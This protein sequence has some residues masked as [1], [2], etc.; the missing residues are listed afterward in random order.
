MG[1][2]KLTPQNG[3]TYI[4][5][6]KDNAGNSYETKLPAAKESG[7]TIAITLQPNARSFLVQRSENAAANFHK[8][9]II[10]TMQQRL[11]YAA[12]IDLSQTPV[13]GGAI[14]VGDLPSGILQ[15]TLFDSGWDAIAER[16]T[17]INND[18]YS[19]EAEVGFSQL[20]TDKRKQNTL[21]IKTPDS[22]SANLSVAVTD[23]GIGMDSSDDIVS[24]L[25][26]TGDIKGN[27]YH[28]YYYFT[29]SSDTLQQQLDLVMLTNGWRRIDWN[30]VV[31]SRYPK[32]K[33]QNDAEYLSLNG[34]VYGPTEQDLK[35]GAFIFM[36]I[37]NPQDTA[38]RTEQ[39]I[40]DASGNFSSPNIILYDTS[41][42]YYRISGIESFANSSVVNFNGSIPAAK[43]NC[44]RHRS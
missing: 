32:I 16:I 1:S 13:T 15:I 28:P 42:I 14:P 37:D 23:A 36:I 26:L 11:V 18:S 30:D 31:R 19:F 29:N 2:F 41:K 5:K 9:Y 44:R 40:V 35:K 8:L 25:L 38:R 4:A 24:R 17:F 27:V 3:E 20:G 21:V 34:K 39:A 22:I 7:A 33:Y 6:W 10:A 12:G 43:N